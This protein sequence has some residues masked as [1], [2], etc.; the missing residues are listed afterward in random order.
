M[1]LQNRV[2]PTGDIIAAPVRGQFTGNRGI[3]SYGPEGR[4]GI[5][6]WTHKHWI[7]CT[8]THPRGRYR[9]PQPAHGWTPLFFADEAVGL[10]AG[11]RPCA[12]CRPQAYAAWKAA[13]A[14][15]HGP[16]GHK[17][18]DDALHRARVTRQ[19]VQIRHDAALTDLPDGAFCLWQG[20]PHLVLGAQ[21][22]PYAPEGYG[23][24]IAR[25]EAR[26]TVLTPQPTLGVL[27]AGFQPR[28]SASV[29]A[30]RPSGPP[31]RG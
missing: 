16:A 29:L 24:P 22:W 26:V 23:A 11:H 17:A 5:S 21:L 30:D 27:G 2:Q 7:I 31:P 18:M 10:A 19:R 28:I 4:L 3:L 9:G 6:R 1:P 12:Y 8:L 20:R 14:S 13:W 25:P 15:A